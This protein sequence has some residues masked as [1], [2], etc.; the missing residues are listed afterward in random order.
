MRQIATALSLVLAACIVRAPT[1]SRDPA[2]A[3]LVTED[4]PRFWEAF[5]ARGRLGTAIALESLYL[6]PGSPGLHDWKRL[7]LQDAMTMARTVDGLAPYYASARES[8]LRAATAA[9]R[10]RETYRKLAALYPDAVFPD[11]YFVVGRLNSGGT[12]SGAGLLIGIEMYGRTDSP[13]LLRMGDWLQQVLRP[14]DDLPGIVA[15]ELIHYQQPGRGGRRLL[16]QSMREGSADFL[17]QMISGLN[18]NSHVHAWV[19]A[20]PGRE[21]ELWAEFAPKM[22]GTD[23]AGWFSS[24]NQKERPKDLGYFIGYRIA[25]AY[26]KKMEDKKQAV[27]D[28]IRMSDSE[29]LL[30]RSGYATRMRN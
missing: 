6:K 2:G 20:Q 7:R 1:T 11:V 8:T 21:Q 19:A 4:I 14:V 29:D 26:Y 3:R 27:R 23:S 28:I 24:E 12:T 9:P 25:E 15:H 13:I 17:G 18:I 5:D 10:I 16:D 22:R 30:A